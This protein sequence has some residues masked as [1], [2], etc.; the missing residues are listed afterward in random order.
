VGKR[1]DERR[2][3]TGIRNDV[4]VDQVVNKVANSS[5]I[6]LDLSDFYP[7]NERVQIDIKDQLWQGIALKEKDFRAFIASND[8]SLYENKSVAIHCS[9]DA[10]IPSWAYMLIAVAVEPFARNI[11]FGNLNDLEKVICIDTINGIE[12]GPFQDERVIIKGCADIPNAEF[13]LVA[14]TKKLTPVVKSLMFG[15]ACSTVP[16]YKKK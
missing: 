12:L 5:L 2:S 6:N 13:A 1:Y 9:A 7:K 4:M 16:L 14:L 15:E 10:I 8:W 3:L 11:T